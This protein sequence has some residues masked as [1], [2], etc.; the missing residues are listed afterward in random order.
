MYT[1]I[2][3][4]KKDGSKKDGGNYSIRQLHLSTD[5]PD[6]FGNKPTEGCFVQ[7]VRCSDDVFELVSV[8]QALEA[9]YCSPGSDVVL[10]VK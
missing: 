9:L 3:K 10:D 4:F 8:G 5:N 1:V 7:V 2:G 6:R